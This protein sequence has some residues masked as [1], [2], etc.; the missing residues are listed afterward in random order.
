[1]NPK[2]SKKMTRKVD[3]KRYFNLKKAYPDNND[4]K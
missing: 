1:M 4:L 3:N 2:Q